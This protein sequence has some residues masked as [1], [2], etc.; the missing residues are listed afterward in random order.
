MGTAATT[1]IPHTAIKHL[2]LII[3]VK[4][5]FSSVLNLALS[6]IYRQSMV[7]IN[8]RLPLFSASLA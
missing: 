3:T 4:S 8:K 5:L 1:D 6:S 7:E 2:H